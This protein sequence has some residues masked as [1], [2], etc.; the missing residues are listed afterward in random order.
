[1]KSSFRSFPLYHPLLK[2]FHCPPVWYINKLLGNDRQSV[3][4]YPS[5]P[6]N[7][8]L[9]SSRYQTKCKIVRSKIWL[10]PSVPIFVL[11][12]LS[13]TFL[14]SFTLPIEN[15]P[16]TVTSTTL[17]QPK[18]YIKISSWSFTNRT[19]IPVTT[20]FQFLCKVHR[21]NSLIFLDKR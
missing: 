5:V 7:W 1:M 16:I 15:V 19:P 8:W 6:F 4:L 10:L 18:I 14:G 20:L 9:V 21:L 3:F 13:V 2:S 11:I 12:C 17:H